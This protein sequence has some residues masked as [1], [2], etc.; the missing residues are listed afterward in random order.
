MAVFHFKI[1]YSRGLA[2]L[3]SSA[4]A[5]TRVV[6]VPVYILFLGLCRRRRRRGVLAHTKD[7]PPSASAS[8]SP[9]PLC[10]PSPGPPGRSLCQMLGPRLRT[11]GYYGRTDGRCGLAFST[12]GSVSRSLCRPLQCRF[13][14]CLRPPNERARPENGGDLVTRGPL[15]NGEVDSRLTLTARS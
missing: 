12:C 3:I 10:P 4:Q 2:S 5:Q 6:A 14:P 1:L 15:T 7:L 9:F 13:V 8:P 11:A